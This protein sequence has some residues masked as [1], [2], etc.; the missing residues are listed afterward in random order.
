LFEL[1]YLSNIINKTLFYCSGSQPGVR[2]PL[3]VHEKTT[4]GTQNSKNSSKEALLGIIFDLEVRK[5]HTILI[6]GYAEGY[7]IDLG[8]HG[9]QKVENPCFTV[10]V[11]MIQGPVSI[12]IFTPGDDYL[13]ALKVGMGYS[14]LFKVSPYQD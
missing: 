6:W 2:I 14:M 9:Y 10:F 12:A 8:V 7:N 5:G 4:G 13:A 1:S 3:G 11:F